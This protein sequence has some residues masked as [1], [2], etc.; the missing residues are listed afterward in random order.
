M[1]D[2]LN[3]LATLAHPDGGWGYVADQ[4]AHLEPTCL[5]LLAL[6]PEAERFATAVVGGRAFLQSCRRPDGSYRLSRGRDAAVWGTALALFTDAAYRDGDTPSAEETA[7]AAVLLGIKGRVVDADPEV[8]DMCDIDVTLAGWPWGEGT[9]SWVEPT[10]W[11]CLALHRLGLGDHPRVREG[12][13]LLLDRAFD[14]GGANYGNRM[15][16]GRMTEPIPGPTAL[17]L[18]ALQGYRTEPRVKAAVGYLCEQL[19]NGH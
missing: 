1:A 7:T 2:H 12:E 16:L 9:F 4:P 18:L 8:A 10:S 3:G 19:A 11:A 14:Q 13:R 6:R 5:A 17:M 15:I